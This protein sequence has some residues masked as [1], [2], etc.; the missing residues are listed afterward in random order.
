M[1]NTLAYFAGQQSFKTL[2][3]FQQQKSCKIFI[4]KSS[5][6][7][8]FSKTIPALMEMKDRFEY[9]DFRSGRHDTQCSD[10]QHNDAQHNGY[11]ATII[12]QCFLFQIKFITEDTNAKHTTITTI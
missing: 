11:S 5:F 9:L 8:D 3:F 6:V 1:T 7:E 4:R 10:T 2:I 12:K